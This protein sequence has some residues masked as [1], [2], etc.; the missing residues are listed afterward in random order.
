[1]GYARGKN[2]LTVFGRRLGASS[3]E[4]AHRTTTMYLFWIILGGIGF[5]LFTTFALEQSF[6]EIVSA[7]GTVGL[8]K[9][10][11]SLLNIP[12][13]LTIIMLMYIGRVGSVTLA[14]ALMEKAVVPHTKA[15]SE[16]IPIG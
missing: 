10:I 1:M 14:T 2:D 8:S 12:A 4:K 9:G 6:F 7:I 15:P 5:S 16:N 11:T 13:K 3:I